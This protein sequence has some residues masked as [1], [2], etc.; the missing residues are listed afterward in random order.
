MQWKRPIGHGKTTSSGSSSSSSSP[1][2]ED[3]FLSDATLQQ[4]RAAD[5]QTRTTNNLFGLQ[6]T[7]V[8]DDPF[9]RRNE[10]SFSEQLQ[11]MNHAL[12]QVFADPMLPDSKAKRHGKR[13]PQYQVKEKKNSGNQSVPSGQC[14]KVADWCRYQFLA[15][16]PGVSMPLSLKYRLFCN[17]VILTAAPVLH[18]WFYPLLLPDVHYVYVDPL[19]HSLDAAM[20][21]SPK[22]VYAAIA[23]EARFL[24]KTRLTT[25]AV[26]CYWRKLLTLALKHFPLVARTGVAAAPASRQEAPFVFGGH[27]DQQRTANQ[28]DATSSDEEVQT[29]STWS[30]GTTPLNPRLHTP[31]SIALWDPKRSDDQFVRKEKLLQQFGGQA[32]LQGEAG[33]ELLGE[34]FQE[35]R[36]VLPFFPEEERYERGNARHKQLL[37]RTR[38]P[39]F[40]TALLPWSDAAKRLRTKDDEL[41]RL[42]GCSATRVDCSSGWVRNGNSV[43]E[44]RAG[45]SYL[46][47][48]TVGVHHQSTNQEDR[49]RECSLMNWFYD[50]GQQAIRDT[51]FNPHYGQVEHHVEQDFLSGA[52]PAPPSSTSAGSNGVSGASASSSTVAVD[53]FGHLPALA[54]PEQTIFQFKED[55]LS[56]PGAPASSS[57]PGRPKN[58]PAPPASAGANTVTLYQN[59][60]D[61]LLDDELDILIMIP[62]CARQ[63]ELMQVARSTYLRRTL[64]FTDVQHVLDVAGPKLVPRTEQVFQNGT[65][66]EVAHLMREN[67]A[68]L[69]RLQRTE[70]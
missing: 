9:K 2:A 56:A 54:A 46:V 47:G 68:A 60:L 40:T 17:S 39:W 50:S 33:Q 4:L 45:M 15:N 14:V 32:Q 64:Y 24:A 28:V 12:T 25:A 21:S 61:F 63:R 66:R 1:G 65:A 6:D 10:G 49:A 42:P 51:M 52:A 62:V 67:D 37:V 36:T 57:A 38:A 27:D 29:S 53:T 48:V 43:A 3:E 69:Y 19:F 34:I 41:D 11:L 58:R 26:D 20:H 18:Q 59:P 8:T 23:D 44:C 16:I 70:R 35:T 55:V 5:E 31:L 7:D 13:V 30:S 22:A